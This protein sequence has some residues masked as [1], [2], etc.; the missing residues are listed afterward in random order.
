M[1]LLI[2]SSFF[3]TMF[4]PQKFNKKQIENQTLVNQIRNLGISD[5]NHVPSVVTSSL[6]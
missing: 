2:F 5:R 1:V 6:S 3:T 4:Q